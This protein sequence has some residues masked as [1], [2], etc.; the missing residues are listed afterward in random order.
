MR[1]LV[2]RAVHERIALGGVAA[3]QDLGRAGD[4]ALRVDQERGAKVQQGG[5]RARARRVSRV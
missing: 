4:A 1:G 2:E 5:L 3:E